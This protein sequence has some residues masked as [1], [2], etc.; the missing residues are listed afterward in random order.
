MIIVIEGISAAG[1][2]TWCAAH[3]PGQTVPETGPLADVPDARAAPEVTARFWAA[4][5]VVRWHAARAMEKSALLAVCD[6]DPFKLHYTWGLRQLGLISAAD[7]LAAAAATRETIAARQLGFADAYFV[8]PI[9]PD[10]ARV[11]AAGDPTRRRRNLDRHVSLQPSLLAWY[12]A[13]DQVLPGR[14]HFAWPPALP[15]VPQQTRYPGVAV[16]DRLI[17]MLPD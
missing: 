6:T 3:A 11:Q 1:K 12:R 7:W 2:S 14:V 5:N 13:I 9:E 16:F 10:R 4:R 8:Q 15:A 17:A